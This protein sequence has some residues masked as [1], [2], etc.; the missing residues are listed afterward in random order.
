[1]QMMVFT[2]LR[3]VAVTKYQN[4]LKIKII[5]VTFELFRTLQ[6]HCYFFMIH[7]Y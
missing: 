6:S 4:E 1:M 3:K 5:A 2:F 7:P